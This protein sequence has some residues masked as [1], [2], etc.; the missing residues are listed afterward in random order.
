MRPI[1]EI[2]IHCT[3]TAEGKDYTVDQIRKW[4]VQ[5]N[6]WKDIGYHY[7]IYRDGSIHAG[8][9]IDQIGAH[10]TNHNT[11]TIGVCYV[12]GCTADGITPKDTRTPQQKAALVE[13]VRS[14]KTVFGI[15]KVS[16][17]R[18]YA[19]KACPSFDVQAWR[20]EVGL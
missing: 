19:A 10:T 9:P 15:N 11:G 13:L 5:G 8:R 17:H 7:V 18:E 4:H 2:I 12:G 16:G 3:A 1:N 14:L 6:G 20:R